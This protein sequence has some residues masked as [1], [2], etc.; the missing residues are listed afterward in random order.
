MK[1]HKA[2]LYRIA[3]IVGAL[4]VVVQAIGAGEKWG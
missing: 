2:R 1:N 3:T 4:M